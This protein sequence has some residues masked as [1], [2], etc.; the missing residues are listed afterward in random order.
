MTH[1]IMEHRALDL[2]AIN[3]QLDGD[4]PEAIVRWAADTFGEGLVMTSSFGAQ[5]A[6][7]IHLVTR[8]VPH[9]PVILID[10]GY[11]FPETYV[12]VETLTKRLNL[13]LKVFQP[14]LSAARHE[15][16]HGRQWEQGS[17]ELVQYNQLRKVEP[18]QRA[19][20]ELRATAWLA[21]LRR[22]QTDHRATLKTAVMQDGLFKIH[23]ILRWSTKEVHQYLTANDLPYHPLYEKGYKS[24]GDTHSTIPITADMHERSGRFHGLKQECGLHLPNTVEEDQSRESSGL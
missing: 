11:L 21:G 24:I 16:L 4:E 13:N 15:S 20:S 1:A 17:D 2:D 7:M 22:D 14:S 8:V 5:A 9:V 18:M 6:V 23:P 19:L 12:F 3:H 10:T